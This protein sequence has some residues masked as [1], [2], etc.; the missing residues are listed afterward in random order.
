MAYCSF[1]KME[2]PGSGACTFCG[3]RNNTGNTSA[4][5]VIQ[6]QIN[7]NR[8]ARN[9]AAHDFQSAQTRL[10]ASMRE[11]DRAAKQVKNSHSKVQKKSSIGGRLVISAIIGLIVASLLGSN[12]TVFWIVAIIVFFCSK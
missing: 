11:M 10:N 4:S 8:N 12:G 7:Q 1:C 6:T 9:Q 5:S 3:R 2:Y